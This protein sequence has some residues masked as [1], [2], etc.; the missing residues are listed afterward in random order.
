MAVQ[1]IFASD[2]HIVGNRRGDFAGTLL[3]IMPEGSAQLLALSAG[4]ESADARDVI[5]TW[6]EESHIAGRLDIASFVTNGDGVG[7]VVDD[8]SSIVPGTILMNETSGEY[9]LVTAS[10]PSTNTITVTRNITGTGAVTMLATDFLQR[11]GTAFEEGSSRPTAVVNLGY[12]RMNYCQIFRNSWDVTGTSRAVDFYVASP[13]A[14]NKADCALFHSE[15]IERSLLWGQKAIGTLNQ[16][17]FRMMDGMYSMITTNVTPGAGSVSYADLDAFF[18]AVFSKN[19]KGKPNE[20]I[21][22][23]GNKGLGILNDIAMN[24]RTSVIELTPRMTEFGKKTT[25]WITPYGTVE[26]MTHPLF[27][28]SP[29]FTGDI[30]VLHPGAIRTRYLRRTNIDNYDANGSRAGVDADFGV[31]TTEMTCEYRAEITGGIFAGMTAADI[32]T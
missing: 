21:A 6:F 15:D 32:P 20:R 19:I 4:M 24:F 10:V 7:V 27:T 11:I 2:A 9:V 18:Q 12:V 16:K 13:P 1:G 3:Q 26:L 25:T 23:T 8:A 30:L 28:E 31:Y 14:K 29:F 22:F 5:V 17:P